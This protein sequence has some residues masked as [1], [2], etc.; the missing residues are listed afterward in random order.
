MSFCKLQLRKRRAERAPAGSHSPETRTSS[1]EVSRGGQQEEHRGL[2]LGRAPAG[3][4][5]TGGGEVRFQCAMSLHWHQLSPKPDLLQDPTNIPSD[6]P[7]SKC[8]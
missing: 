2:F 6:A 1:G 4:G 7:R 3:V 8:S 5:G